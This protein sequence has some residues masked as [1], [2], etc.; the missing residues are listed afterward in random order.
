V[1]ILQKR[2]NAAKRSKKKRIA[3]ALQKYL[4]QM[5]PGRRVVGARV[6]RLKGGTLKIT[7]ITPGRNNVAAGFVDE[8][9]IF[10]PIRAS[11][12]YDRGRGGDAKRKAAKGKK[13]RAKR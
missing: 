2:L 7:P 1:T 12:D 5:N 4:Q 9:G 3:K 10:H 11:Y 8:E 13:K 6:Q